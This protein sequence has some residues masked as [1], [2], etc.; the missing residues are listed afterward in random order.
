MKKLCE[1]L[2]VNTS[3]KN[4]NGDNI[5]DIIKIVFKDTK[6]KF[7]LN[8]ELIDVNDRFRIFEYQKKN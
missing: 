1:Q 5:I 4:T 7:Y 8:S 6:Y 2:N 3:I